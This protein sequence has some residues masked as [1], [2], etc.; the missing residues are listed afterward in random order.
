MRG[1]A[2]ALRA[3]FKEFNENV[4]RGITKALNERHGLHLRDSVLATFQVMPNDD[5]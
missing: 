3:V 4:A 2:A 1:R 5:H